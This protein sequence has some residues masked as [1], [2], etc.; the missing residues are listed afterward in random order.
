MSTTNTAPLTITGR[1]VKKGAGMS[2]GL[3]W[4]EAYLPFDPSAFADFQALAIKHSVDGTPNWAVAGA[5]SPELA[6]KALDPI[7]SHGEAMIQEDVIALAH[8][9]L[10]EYGQRMDVMHDQTALKGTRVVETFVNTAEIASPHFAPGAWVT[11]IKLEPGSE[12]WADVESGA[13]DAVS[14]QANVVKIPI[15][16]RAPDPEA[17]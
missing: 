1:V 17:A 3:I 12:E 6:A 2:E 9:Y 13:L 7:D 4:V 10:G 16:V 11:V 5:V 8:A 14:F 15:V